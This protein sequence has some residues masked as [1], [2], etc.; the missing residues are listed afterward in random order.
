[1]AEAGLGWLEIVVLVN[2]DLID[3]LR[4]VYHSP[5]AIRACGCGS[6]SYVFRVAPQSRCAST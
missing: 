5:V 1:L 2:S 3:R 4:I 6:H